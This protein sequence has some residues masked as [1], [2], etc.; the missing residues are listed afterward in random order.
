MSL[1]SIGASI[2]HRIRCIA[3]GGFKINGPPEMGKGPMSNEKELESSTEASLPQPTQAGRIETCMELISKAMR[4]LENN[5]KQCTMRLIGE[6]IR[7]D[8]N[9]GNVVNK[10]V[11]SKVKDIVHK[12]WLRS[13]DEKRC[14]LL[15]MLRRLV[16]KGWIRGALHR[17]NEA[18]NMWLVRC[19]IDWKSKATRN[20][21]IK[22][23]EDMLREKFS[24]NEV[25]MC[26]EM[27]QF[28][29]VDVNEFRRHGIEPCSWLEGLEELS[30]LKKPYWFGMKASDLGIMKFT[31]RIKLMLNTTNTIDA[32]FFAKLLSTVKVPSLI[33]KWD[34]SSTIIA[35]YIHRTI[36]LSYYIDL[37]IDVWPWPI[38]FSVD[39]FEKILN[40]FTD[41]ELSM[42]LAG[43]IDGDGT[44]CAFIDK[45]KYVHAIVRIVACKAC[46][47]R[48]ILDLLKEVIAKKF[49]IIG[50]IES[51]ETTDGLTFHSKNAVRLLRRIVKYVHHPLRR[52]RAELILAYYEGRIDEKE[53][54]RLYEQTEYVLGGPDVKRNHAL[55]ALTRAAPQTHTHR[56]LTT[57]KQ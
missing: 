12:L 45:E 13:D 39:E 30:D 54:E 32:V 51:Y 41:E 38:E 49:G 17:S 23:I 10:E 47:K 56:V 22:S 31:R 3:K 43:E 5:D 44:I 25:K 33:I 57:I 50:H 28:I 52:L 34:K 36:A 27:W 19:N 20:D 24:W 40:S 9:N 14:K 26:E 11:T 46:P 18:L 16:S 21:V 53:F 48:L 7:L 2:M 55:E 35:K 37:G 8:C 42:F 6:M 15:R 4:C 1:R 29:G